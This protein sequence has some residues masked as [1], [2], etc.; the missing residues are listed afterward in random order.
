MKDITDMKFR[1]LFVNRA[2]VNQ[3]QRQ[4]TFLD[5]VWSLLPI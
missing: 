3:P 4:L 5:L 2:G 1:F